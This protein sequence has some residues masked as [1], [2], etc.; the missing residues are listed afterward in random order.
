MFKVAIR[1]TR[2]APT[3][4]VVVGRYG[5]FIISLLIAGFAILDSAGSSRARESLGIFVTCT[6]S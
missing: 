3:S 6:H 2:A 1:V 5:F 4:V